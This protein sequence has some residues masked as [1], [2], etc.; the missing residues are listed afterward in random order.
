VVV[1]TLLCAASASAATRYVDDNHRQCPK[2]NFSTIRA[3]IDAS[4]ADDIVRV[5]AGTYAEQLTLPAD[6]PGLRV[7]SL[8]AR[9]AHLVATE[10]LATHT[11][12]DDIGP[13]RDL[14]L[15]LGA[16]QTFDD[17]SLKGPLTSIPAGECTGQPS[18]IDIEGDDARVAGNLLTSL[19]DDPC[20]TDGYPS[21]FTI[22]IRV[23]DA[24]AVVDSNTIRGAAAGIQFHEATVTASATRNV[25]VGRNA[26]RP[27]S[28][29]PSWGILVGVVD[30][31]GG[32]GATVR[33]NYVS[34]ASFG[35]DLDF[36]E[37]VVS[38]NRVHDNGTG[39]L[40]D[41]GATGDI[42]SNIVRT[43]RFDGIEAPPLPHHSLGRTHG[44]TVR[45]NSVIGNGHDGIAMYGCIRD[46]LVCDT[47]TK[48]RLDHNVSLANRHLD[49]FDDGFGTSDTWRSNIGLTDRP[50]VCSPR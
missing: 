12:P 38:R 11:A 34:Q 42:S 5:C 23:S 44:L 22:G 26:L 3:A 6:K 13:R 33:S 18:A 45:S 32:S 24:G 29:N 41:D 9:A 35:I 19:P 1:T 37:G 16:G 39:I 15:V 49:C 2:A 31:S 46:D 17:F 4:S 43:N 14:V 8:P 50:H 28:L 7:I 36:G 40:L 10:G 30:G 20:A 25:V 47:L 27:R 48:V 21:S